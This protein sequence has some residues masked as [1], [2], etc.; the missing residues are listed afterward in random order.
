MRVHPEG[1]RLSRLADKTL[2]R[3]VFGEREETRRYVNLMVANAKAISARQVSAG[4]EPERLEL[5][6][7]AALGRESVAVATPEDIA[8]QLR[9]LYRRLIDDMRA[10]VLD[11][12]APGH[13][14]A[15][16]H[17]VE[18]TLQRLGESSPKVLENK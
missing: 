4:G 14:A 16:G 10:G 8:A 9:R 2:G 18:I 11:P 7:L 5:E 12:G 6:S 17:L 1:A 13:E 3:D 15:R